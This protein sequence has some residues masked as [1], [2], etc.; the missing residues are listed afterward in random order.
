MFL[1]WISCLY[2]GMF[3]NVKP[4]WLMSIFIPTSCQKMVIHM[5]MNCTNQFSKLFYLCIKK[6]KLFVCKTCWKMFYCLPF[7]AEWLQKVANCLYLFPQ[8]LLFG[9]FVFIVAVLSWLYLHLIS[10]SLCKFV[11][12]DCHHLPIVRSRYFR[13]SNQLVTYESKTNKIFLSILIE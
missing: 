4:E 5:W 3:F 13:K 9:V 10:E 12:L 7:A 1:T 6:G 2:F 11:C 8:W